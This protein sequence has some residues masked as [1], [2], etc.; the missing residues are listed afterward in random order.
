M[1]RH[2]RR[3]AANRAAHQA[4]HDRFFK[5]Y[6]RHLPKVPVGTIERGTVH[7]L[8]M[9]H[10]SWCA[11][12]DKPNGTALDCNCNPILTQYAVPKDT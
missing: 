3:R 2:E 4:F 12:Y 8:A 10:D 7:I 6:V 1:N 5:D 9:Q 11:I